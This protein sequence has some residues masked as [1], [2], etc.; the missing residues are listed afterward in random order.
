MPRPLWITAGF[1]VALTVGLM[2][3]FTADVAA[4]RSVRAVLAAPN[5]RT[6]VRLEG[7]VRPVGVNQLALTDSTGEIRLSTC[8]AWY[9]PLRFGAGE[10]VRVVGHLAPRHLWRADR[11][12]FVVYGME[13]E[14]GTR[15]TLRQ[16]DGVPLWHRY[17]D[18]PGRRLRWETERDLTSAN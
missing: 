5:A 11:P 4:P 14:Y 17:R 2:T 3:A 6:L 8:P 16:N 15:V 9:R 12:A 13:G 10:R 7:T 18:L 1:L